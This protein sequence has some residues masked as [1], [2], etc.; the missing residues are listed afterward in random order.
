MK[1]TGSLRLLTIFMLPGKKIVGLEEGSYRTHKGD[2]LIA[3]RLITVIV[4]E[5]Y[6]CQGV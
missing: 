4:K 1:P 2:K 5:I 3:A 6:H